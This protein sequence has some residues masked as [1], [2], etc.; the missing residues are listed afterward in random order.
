MYCICPTKDRELIWKG[1]ID[2]TDPQS[3]DETVDDYVK[4]II[5]AIEKQ[6]LINSKNNKENAKL[7][8]KK[9]G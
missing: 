6:Q 5:L 1:Y 3:I 9:S 8:Y 2:I 7:K 4:L